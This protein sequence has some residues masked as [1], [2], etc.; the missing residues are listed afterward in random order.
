[1]T[2]RNVLSGGAGRTHARARG[3]RRG[4]WLLML[5]VPGAFAFGACAAPADEAGGPERAVLSGAE[6]TAS[7]EIDAD[8]AQIDPTPSTGETPSAG[9]PWDDS[10]TAACRGLVGAGLSQVAQSADAEGVTTFWSAGEAWAVCDV[11]SGEP[12]LVA[13]ADS[14]EGFD[15]GSLS[16]TSVALADDG[17]VRHTAAGLLPWPVQELAYTYPDQH[18]ERARFVSSEGDPDEVWW[19]VSYTATEGPLAEPDVDTAG[20]D[21]VTVSVAGGAAEAFRFDWDELQR[22]E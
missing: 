7:P 17:G 16:L 8:E 12:V 2:L 21:P 14:V 11:A 3:A 5:A 20:L 1:M 22:S 6:T 4:S 13:A 10:V 9:R 19:V 18:T 15:E